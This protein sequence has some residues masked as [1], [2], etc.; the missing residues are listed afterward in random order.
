MFRQLVRMF[1]SRLA[2]TRLGRAARFFSVTIALGAVVFIGVI[3]VSEGAMATTARFATI[4]ARWS[5]WLVAI[6]IALAASHQRAVADRRDGIEMLALARG[7][8]GS[9]LLAVRALAAFW[10]SLRWM[11]VP[12]ICAAVMSMATSGSTSVL[13][14]RAK[15][16]LAVVLFAIA[17]SLVLGPLGAIADGL[18]PK[19][20]RS[21]FIAALILSGF[22]A[23]IARDPSLSITGG[24]GQ[25][26]RTLL[27]ALGVG[28]LA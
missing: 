28:R 5:M 10:F 9:R 17:S 27:H 19:R 2:A 14:D 20:G 15:V 6:C 16:L 7:F 25:L 1:S 12:A 8:D 13:F 21:V 4:S 23:E 24:L 26:L 22:L 11:L 18:A 3:R